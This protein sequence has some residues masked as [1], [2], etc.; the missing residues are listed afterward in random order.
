MKR[1]IRDSVLRLFVSL[2]P[3]GEYCKKIRDK[4]YLQIPTSG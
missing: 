2:H 1:L 4:L 3:T